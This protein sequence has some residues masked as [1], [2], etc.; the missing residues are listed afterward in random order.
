M[1]RI[2]SI[3]VL[4]LTF[5]AL[6]R[7][8][9][10]EDGA[11]VKGQVVLDEGQMESWDKQKLEVAFEE[12]ESRLIEVPEVP[13]APVPDNWADMKPEDRFQ[14]IQE[15]EASDEGKA[16]TANRKRIFDE[17]RKFDVSIESNGSFVVF[18][19]P[20]GTYGLEGRVDKVIDGVKYGFEIFGRIEVLKDVDEIELDPIQVAVTPQLEPGQ[21][22]PPISVKTHDNKKVLTLDMF[23]GKYL[24]VCFWISASPSAEY[25]SKLQQMYVDLKDK[26]P[27]Q[28]LA[29]SVDEDRK[30]AIDYIVQQKLREGSHGFT[31]GLEDPT[32]FYYGVRSFPSFWLIDPEGKIAM[33]QFEFAEA[34]RFENDLGVIINK[35]ILGKDSP[36]PAAKPDAADNTEEK[37]N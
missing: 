33:T 2:I 1:N 15:F 32:L 37:G 21:A 35:R 14:W 24:L 29:I 16:F 11:T 26:Q 23:K 36:T 9:C 10:A 18:D 34:F 8:A 4:A 30:Q 31:D 20:P 12:I 19:V 6:G 13:S 28:L 22:A 17:R 3:F 5:V 27:L 7:I 25:Q